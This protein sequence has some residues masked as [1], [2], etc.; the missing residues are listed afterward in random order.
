MVH[1]TGAP[2]FPLCV[3]PDDFLV[4]RHL[5]ARQMRLFVPESVAACYGLSEK[6]IDRL[7]TSGFSTDEI[8]EL[9]YCSC[10]EV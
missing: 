10:G 3:L 9:I 2:S 1:I 6:A 8:E 4:L 7:L 5:H